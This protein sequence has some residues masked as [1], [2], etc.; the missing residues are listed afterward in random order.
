M[1][2]YTRTV[3]RLRVLTAEPAVFVRWVLRHGLGSVYLKQLAK[4]GDPHSRLWFDGRSRLDLAGLQDE[5]RGGGEVV[6]GKGGFVVT[7]HRVAKTVMARPKEYQNLD[8]SHL[9]APW[10]FRLYRRAGRVVFSDPFEYPALVGLEGDRL[11]AT[12]ALFRHK[13]SRSGVVAIRPTLEERAKSLC[14]DLR[15][16]AAGGRI[17][18]VRDYAQRLSQEVLSILFE[19]DTSELAD[20]CRS[21]EQLPRL[22]DLGLSWRDFRALVRAGQ[23]LDRWTDARIAGT[24]ERSSSIIGPAVAAMRRGEMRQ[25]EL[26]R[27]INLILVASYATTISALTSGIKLLL[28]HPDQLQMLVREPELWANATDEVLRIG[29]PVLLIP[30]WTR[31][32][33]ELGG[34]DMKAG[35]PVYISGV[36]KDPVQYECPHALRVNRENAGSHM[37]FGGGAHRCLGA[38]LA[39]AEIEIGLRSFFTEY[40][41]SVVVRAERSASRLVRTWDEVIVQ[42]QIRQHDHDPVVSVFQ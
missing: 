12:R 25:E 19:V 5:L 41:G 38:T 33:S 7:S 17:D 14:A 26:R 40:A 34:L 20:V 22:M 28:E 15:D 31:S 4:S 6:R 9:M 11:A 1:T 16:R 2:R 39:H 18:L 35:R 30:R 42:L 8:A 24:P 21:I 10:M 23:R 36:D 29:G 32:P 13:F 37:A 3:S 27:S